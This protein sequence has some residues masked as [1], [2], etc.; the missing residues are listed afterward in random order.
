MTDDQILDF[1]ANTANGIVARL[2]KARQNG[3]V[4]EAIELLLGRIVGAGN[5][6]L[7]LRDK[8]PHNF[9]FDGAMVL[10]GVYDAMLQALYILKDASARNERARLYLDY[11]WVEKKSTLELLDRNPTQF[12][13]RISQSP[14]RT[15]AEPAIE[16]EY[17]RVLPQFQNKKGKPRDHWY[18]GNLRD[19]ARSVGLEPEYE[20]LQRQ[21]S[22]VVHSSSY[23]LR[24][25]M[26]MGDFLLLDLV[27][28]FSFR[29]LGQ[30]AEYAGIALDKVE[31]DLVS[32]SNGIVFD[33]A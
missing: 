21:L 18:E 15:N 7:V 1:Q 4:T 30:F 13:K 3:P 26:P 11:F 20:I 10:R 23:A 5:S 25:G 16:S 8:S 9:I 22:G 29:V 19:L 2:N 12:A 33:N 6:L 17:Q 27:W 31:L 32:I 28:R 24:E 14:R